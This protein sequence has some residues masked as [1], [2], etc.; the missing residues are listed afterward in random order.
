VVGVYQMNS[1]KTNNSINKNDKKRLIKVKFWRKFLRLT[2][3][4]IPV[5]K[6]LAVIANEEEDEELKGKI[7]SVLAEMERGAIMSEALEKCG[8]YFSASVIELVRSAEKTAAWD[9]IL[10][11]IAEGIE[12]GT[13]D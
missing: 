3:G 9:N 13:F 11:E 12:E 4:M 5:M 7:K 8:D 2:R 6:A 10:L 1:C